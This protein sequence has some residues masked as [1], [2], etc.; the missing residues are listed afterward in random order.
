MGKVKAKLRS[1]ILRVNMKMWTIEIFI[2]FQIVL[3]LPIMLDDEINTIRFRIE[4]G[5]EKG[6]DEIIKDEIKYE[7]KSPEKCI[8]HN[9][10]GLPSV[11]P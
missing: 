7:A 10:E 1:K 11:L 9:F 4:V 3:L 5:I 2:R 8:N 6:N